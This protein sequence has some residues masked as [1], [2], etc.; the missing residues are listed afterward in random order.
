MDLM[1][2][3]TESQDDA[4]SIHRTT[5]GMYSAVLTRTIDLGVR[6]DSNDTK[7]DL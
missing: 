1:Q 2:N 5:D 7:E 3:E 4:V 6:S